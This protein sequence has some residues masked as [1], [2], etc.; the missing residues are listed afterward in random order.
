MLASYESGSDN[1]GGQYDSINRT[2]E[3]TTPYSGTYEVIE[4]A[5]E[6]VDL[7]DCDEQTAAAIRFMVSKGYFSVDDAGNF[8]PNGTLNRY[9]FAEALVRMFFALDRSLTTSFTDVPQDSP[10]YA[11]VASGEQDDI[12]EGFEDG[13]F[14]G[15]TDVMREQVIALC[16]RTLADKKGY[17]YPAA[18]PT[19]DDAPDGGPPT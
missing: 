8:D 14:R 19:D 10:Y 3:F 4:N 16:S 13:T 12:I 18:P 7:A 15:E 5:A 11:Y 6:I 1:W 2:I 9:T 17:S